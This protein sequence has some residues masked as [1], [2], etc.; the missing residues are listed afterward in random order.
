MRSWPSYTAMLI[1]A[2]LLFAAGLFRIFDH[3]IGGQS[4]IE[5]DLNQEIS[6]QLGA[7]VIALLVNG[8]LFM[9]GGILRFR[10]PTWGKMTI[11]TAILLFI[12][13]STIQLI[14]VWMGSGISTFTY[15]LLIGWSFSTA[16]MVAFG[17]ALRKGA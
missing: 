9:A 6:A 7:A 12:G 2:I 14:S 10:Q 13:G 17:M 16:L 5:G 4:Q 8:A 11:L 3:Y 1:G 15:L